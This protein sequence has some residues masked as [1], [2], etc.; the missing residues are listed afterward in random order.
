MKKQ[1]DIE[2]TSY[3]TGREKADAPSPYGGTVQSDFLIET[4]ENQ[5]VKKVKKTGKKFKLSKKAIIISSVVLA[6]F[7]C[8]GAVFGVFTYLWQN[9]KAV[10]PAFISS[11]GLY[12]DFGFKYMQDIYVNGVDISGMTVEKASIAIAD[13]NVN[14]NCSIELKLGDKTLVLTSADLTYTLENDQVLNEAKQYSIDVMTGKAQKEKKEYNAAICLSEQSKAQIIQKAQQSLNSDPVDATFQGI[15][16][17]GPVFVSEVKGTVVDTKQLIEDIESFIA[18]GQSKGVINVKA[19]FLMPEITEADL[20]EKVTLLATHST[21]SANNANGNANM[22]KA[23]EMCNGSV[24]QPG[25]VWSFNRCT[26]DSNLP[27]DGWLPATVYSGGYLAT[28]YGGGICQAS[29]TIYV[30]ALYADLGVEERYSHMWAAGYAKAGFDATI[31]YPRIDLKL[32]NNTEYPMYLE[33]KMEGKTLTVNI[34]GYKET[35]Y[36]TITLSSQTTEYVED[37]HY[38]VESYRTLWLEGK[39][40]STEKLP[41]SKYSLKKQQTEEEANAS[42]P[43]ETPSQPPVESEPEQ[44]EPPEEETPSEEVDPPQEVTPPDQGGEGEEQGNQGEDENNTG[45]EGFP[46]LPG[47]D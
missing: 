35:H 32:K 23:M 20:R 10:M 7:V 45:L 17:N 42:K 2:Q 38:N 19:D 29:T 47:S 39:V 33:C 9:G 21:V 6:V 8:L 22:R 37:S 24:I 40:V 31:D 18:N 25:E 28:G 46:T 3:I 13:S 44:E 15:G 41:L 27:E 12:Q 1:N 4:D 16:E 26:G 43:E 34:Y 30:A 14:S 5:T 11:T 36:D